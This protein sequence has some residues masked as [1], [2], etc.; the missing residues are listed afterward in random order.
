[1]SITAASGIAL[2]I[3]SGVSAATLSY[4]CEATLD[5]EKRGKTSQAMIYI[6]DGSQVTIT[7]IS[8]FTSKFYVASEQADLIEWIVSDNKQNL[9]CA[10]RKSQ[11]MG[12]CLGP[13]GQP[14]IIFDCK[15]VVS[16]G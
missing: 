15:K 9:T 10:F 14:V 11:T 5:P 3:G 12:V 2:A 6:V 8:T 1:L 13:K 7:G 16:G 4:S